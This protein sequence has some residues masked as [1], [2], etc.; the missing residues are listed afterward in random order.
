MDTIYLCC[1]SD[2][3]LPPQ[4]HFAAIVS[5]LVT[6]ILCLITT[7]ITYLVE[8]YTVLCIFNLATMFVIIMFVP[9]SIYLL[10]YRSNKVRIISYW[11]LYLAAHNGILAMMY[12]MANNFLAFAYIPPV[13]LCVYSTI[14]VRSCAVKIDRHEVPEFDFS[15]L[16]PTPE[17]LVEF[18]L[19]M[20]CAAI[21]E[22]DCAA[23]LRVDLSLGNIKTFMEV[24]ID[25]DAEFPVKAADLPMPTTDHELPEVKVMYSKMRV[26]TLD[27]FK[28]AL[29]MKKPLPKGI[30][31][32]RGDD[33]RFEFAGL[34]TIDIHMELEFFSSAD[35]DA[36]HAKYIED[37]V[38]SPRT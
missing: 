37:Y 17:Q 16:G 8:D 12:A 3:F 18:I 24:D 14:V 22:H 29:H 2:G 30:T 20:G 33:V 9:G 7:F 36:E 19:A 27:W 34:V 13:L 11:L 15:T 21:T 1:R 23:V 32:K 38:C 26:D 25:R 10:W 6:I 4:I 31:A 5:V 28:K 35:Y